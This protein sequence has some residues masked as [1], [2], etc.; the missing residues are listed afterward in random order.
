MGRIPAPPP[1]PN[2]EAIRSGLARIDERRRRAETPVER[3]WD[4]YRAT[5]PPELRDDDEGGVQNLQG[6]PEQ[7]APASHLRAPAKL[8]TRGG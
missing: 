8:Q 2:Y 5:T 3:L 4:E 1:P 7:D 6:S